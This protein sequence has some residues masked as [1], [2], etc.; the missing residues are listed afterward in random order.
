[1]RKKPLFVR[2]LFV[3]V[4]ITCCLCAFVIKK[5]K[6]FTGIRASVVTK[7]SNTSSNSFYVSNRSPLQKQYFIKLPVTAFT[8]GGWMKK[9]LELQRD[10]LTGHLGE[11]SIWLSKKDNAWLNKEGKGA[12]GWEELPY[13]LKGYANIGYVLQD[14]KMID[15]AMFWINAVLA[16]QRDNGDFGPDVEKGA[17]KRDLWT[18]MPMLWCL[19]SYYEYSGDKRVLSLMTKYFKWQLTIPDDKFLEDYWEKSRG[20]DE[21]SSVYWL[22]NLTGDTFLLELGTKI[23]RNTANWRQADNLAN[24]HNVNIAQSFREPA[25]YYQQSGNHADIA[26]TYNNFRLVRARYG[27]VPGGMFGG[28]ENVRKGYSDPRQAIETCGMVEQMTSDNMLLGITG[29]PSWADNAE[30]IA[31]NMYPAAFMPDYKALRYLTAPNMTVS[32]SKNH[33]PGIDNKGPF[34]MMNP[35]SSRCCQHNH[36]AGWVYYLE[37]SWMATPD[38]GIAA[39]LYLDG[40]VKAKV[41]DD[42]EVQFTAATHYPF[43]EDVQVQLSMTKAVEFPL[44]LRIPSWAHNAVVKVNGKQVAVKA[45]AG[46]YIK[47]ENQWKNGDK[48]S[49]HLPMALDVRTWTNNKNSVSINYGPLTYSLKIA[50]SYIKQDSRE[51]AVWDSKWQEG[52]DQQKWPSYEIFATSPWNY[53]LLADAALPA[54]YFRVVKKQWPADNNPFGVAGAPVEI[55]AKGKRIADW[56]FDSTGLTGVLPQSPVAANTAVEELTLIPMGG[57]RLRIT[58]FPVVEK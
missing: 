28:D 20:G 44:Y 47:L 49:L 38:N 56:G 40:I 6:A 51:T 42:T 17:G 14:K 39:Q 35:F 2:A 25:Q 48:L 8:A 33:H 10:G 27:Q 36:A 15:E 5:D 55:K 54:K 26:A 31:F 22:Y 4:L 1:M 11:I 32:D 57:A 3:A 43:E 16:N 46:Q 7:P 18:N 34:L 21:L 9:Q 29:D 41:G 24:W 50:E 19:Q 12:H 13:W 30:D 37:H 58:A 52:A 53:G 45:V 23:D